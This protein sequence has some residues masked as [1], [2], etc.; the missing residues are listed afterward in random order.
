[1]QNHTAGFIFGGVG[2]ALLFFTSTIF[3]EQQAMLIRNR[4]RNMLVEQCADAICQGSMTEASVVIHRIN[5]QYP[6]RQKRIA[7]KLTHCVI[8]EKRSSWVNALCFH[9]VAQLYVASGAYR[10][11]GESYVLAGQF[12]EPARDDRSTWKKAEQAYLLAF[13]MFILAK[14]Q[15]QLRS[16]YWMAFA[17]SRRAKCLA[18][19][20]NYQEACH[21]YAKA[22]KLFMECGEFDKA[23][24]CRVKQ[25]WCLQKSGEK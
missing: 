23:Q 11:A 4:H 1:M 22:E 21:G 10:M 7:Q 19:M 2:I 3:F 24:K 5:Q 6:T 18:E 14:K 13:K 17:L 20:G 15:K 12:S 16:P 9:L 8:K 25:Q